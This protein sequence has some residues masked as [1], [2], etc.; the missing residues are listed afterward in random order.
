MHG[1]LEVQQLLRQDKRR[2]AALRHVELDTSR[3]INADNGL[4]LF[5]RFL[6]SV[7]K[8]IIISALVKLVEPS[9]SD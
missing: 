3:S 9:S 7:A 5:S 1:L 2:S 6:P 8:H 4:L